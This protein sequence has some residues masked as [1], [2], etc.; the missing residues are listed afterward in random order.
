V[1]F[2]FAVAVYGGY[3][4]AGIGILMLASLGLLGFQDVHEMNALK[5]MMGFLI[6]VIAATYFIGSGLVYWPAAGIMVLG[7]I[8]GGYFGAHFAQRVPQG[9]VRGMITAI[10]LIISAVMFYK[11]L[12]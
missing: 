9:R 2:Q 3:F 7:T 10:G 11:Q 5:V 6:N 4:G 12:R 1:A 8:L